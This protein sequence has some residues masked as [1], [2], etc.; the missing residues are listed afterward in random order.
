MD[1][2]VNSVGSEGERGL[3]KFKRGQLEVLE[4]ES[5]P[6]LIPVEVLP[7]TRPI[8]PGFTAGCRNGYRSIQF[9]TA[10]EGLPVVEGRADAAG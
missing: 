9:N 2:C 3:V 10:G 7:S 4:V 5:G 8:L 1:R 6:P